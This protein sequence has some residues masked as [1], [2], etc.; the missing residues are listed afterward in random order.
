MAA[1][2]GGIRNYIDDRGMQA[3]KLLA[4][5]VD[6]RP[7]VLDEAFTRRKAACDLHQ[8]STATLNATHPLPVSV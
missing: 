1:A 3:I 2:N 6:G 5:A 8:A 7:H 4:T